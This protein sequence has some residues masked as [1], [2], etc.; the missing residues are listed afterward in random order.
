MIKAIDPQY[1]VQSSKYHSTFK[2]FL[3]ATQ[4][5]AELGPVNTAFVV[6]SVLSDLLFVRPVCF[7]VCLLICLHLF[8]LSD[9]VC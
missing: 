6:L 5:K 9:F 8:L 3:V 4:L 7:L 2:T 1:C